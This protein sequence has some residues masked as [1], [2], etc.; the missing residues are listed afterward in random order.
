MGDR[1]PRAHGQ[2][3]ADIGDRCGDVLSLGE[4]ARALEQAGELAPQHA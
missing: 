4:V 3:P 1:S 2:A